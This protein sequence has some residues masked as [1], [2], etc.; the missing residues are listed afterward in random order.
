MGPT[1]TD[2]TRK[3]RTPEECARYSRSHYN[4]DELAPRENVEPVIVGPTITEGRN[5]PRE[6][7]P[8]SPQP[9]ALSP[10]ELRFATQRKVQVL[11]KDKFHWVLTRR[12][13]ADST[14]A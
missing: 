10:T 8:P 4:Q 2:R 5:G 13:A 7:G 1:I 12:W 6:G 14:E 11:V 3:S 9:R